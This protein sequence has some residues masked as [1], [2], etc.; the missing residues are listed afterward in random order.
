MSASTDHLLP[1]ARTQCEAVKDRVS[2]WFR[3]QMRRRLES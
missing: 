1:R 3:E 2:W